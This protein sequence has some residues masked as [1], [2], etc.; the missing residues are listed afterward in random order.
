ME[1]LFEELFVSNHW[2]S[3][4]LDTIFLFLFYVSGEPDTI[5]RGEHF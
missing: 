2:Y 5:K 1:D 4:T 3:L